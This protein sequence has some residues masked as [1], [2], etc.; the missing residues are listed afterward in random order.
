MRPIS[1]LIADESRGLS[2]SQAQMHSMD[3]IINVG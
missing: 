1:D 2:L 3:T